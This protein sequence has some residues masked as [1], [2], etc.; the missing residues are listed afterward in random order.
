MFLHTLYDISNSLVRRYFV[1]VLG[2]VICTIFGQCI[3]L[4]QSRENNVKIEHITG[5]FYV[6]TTYKNI[7]GIPFPSNSVYIVT[8][9][10]VVLFD[11]PWDT[12][13]CQPLLDS[14]YNRH[15]KK[16]IMC[17]VTHFHDDRTAGLEYFK[18]KGIKTLS[19]KQTYMLCKKRNE[20]SAEYYF[21]DDTV[22]A[23]G[24]Y[25]FRTYYAGKGH[26]DDNIV[27]WCDSVKVLYGGCL[28][29]ST[30][31]NGLGNIADADITEWK[32][33]ISKLIKKYPK[34]C[35]IIPGHFDWRDK[36]SLKHTLKLLNN[37]K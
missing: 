37:H 10:G 2:I 34:A 6:Y 35:Y 29:K 22:F 23:V 18:S 14:I 13:Q 8:N 9:K 17:I 4:A 26:S 20:K 3:T 28:V 12:T 21:T 7:N 16:V 24:Q 19:S 33:T 32:K 1:P 30:E 31:N 36:N 11:T 15:Q 25:T 27:I 5:D